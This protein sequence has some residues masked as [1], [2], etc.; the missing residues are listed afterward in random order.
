MIKQTDKGYLVESKSTKGEF[1]T[2]SLD[3]KTCDCPKFKYY[4]KGKSPCHH[5]TQAETEFGSTLAPVQ[6]V[7]EFE[8]FVPETYNTPLIDYDFIAKYGE[9]QL[10]Y[11]LKIGEVIIMKNYVRRL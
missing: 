9:K 5:I 11:L 2:V 1:W 3:F 7:G 10:D 6:Q 4:L 8:K